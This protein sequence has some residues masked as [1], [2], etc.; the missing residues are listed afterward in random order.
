MLIEVRRPL[1]EQEWLSQKPRYNPWSHGFSFTPQLCC[2]RSPLTWRHL[3]ELSAPRAA[4][5]KT[6]FLNSWWRPFFKFFVREYNSDWWS[7][8]IEFLYQ[9]LVSFFWIFDWYFTQTHQNF[10]E[11][12][13]YRGSWGSL[14]CDQ[15]NANVQKSWQW[16]RGARVLS[17]DCAV[18]MS[19]KQKKRGPPNFCVKIF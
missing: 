1:L 16:R 8:I 12:L 3:P 13:N 9:V 18:H 14:T 2:P 6:N 10:P 5:W 15:K 19:K 4:A 7:A 11:K 17:L